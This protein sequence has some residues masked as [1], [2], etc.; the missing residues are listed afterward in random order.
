M[1]QSQS[2]V[3]TRDLC[4]ARENQVKPRHVTFDFFSH[5]SENHACFWLVGA[6]ARWPRRCGHYDWLAISPMSRLGWWSNN[7]ITGFAVSDY[8]WPFHNAGP[9]KNYKCPFPR[10]R[11]EVEEGL[12]DCKCP[13]I[14]TKDYRPVCGTDGKTYGNMC[15]LEAAACLTKHFKLKLKHLGECKYTVT[16]TRK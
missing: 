11:C 10:T 7:I 3:K 5:W 12:P 16:V 9:C 6:Q 4:Q 2:E 15:G 13:I 8:V 14:C 1:N